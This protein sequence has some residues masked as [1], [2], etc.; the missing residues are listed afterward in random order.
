MKYNGLLKNKLTT[1]RYAVAQLVE[2]LR[3]KPMV[4]G[5]ITD[6]VIDFLN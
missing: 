4:T 5:S 3:Y 1:P 6:G 2:V